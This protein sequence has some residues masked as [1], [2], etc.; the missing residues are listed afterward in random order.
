MQPR[1]CEGWRY[2]G[3]AWR[4]G[5]DGYAAAAVTR[6]CLRGLSTGR[7]GPAAGYI[8]AATCATGTGCA[9]VC[10]PCRSHWSKGAVGRDL[11]RGFACRTGAAVHHPA[12]SADLAAHALP[13]HLPVCCNRPLKHD[14]TYGMP[15]ACWSMHCIQC[16]P[17]R[18]R[19]PS[20][21]CSTVHGSTSSGTS[22][23]T[24]SRAQAPAWPD[25]RRREP[26]G[27]TPLLRAC[28]D[29]PLL[30]QRVRPHC[31]PRGGV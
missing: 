6:P 2:G 5:A 28:L 15:H 10:S 23:W 12:W 9:H 17:V 22:C 30:G 4:T 20:C 26:V 27:G 18:P 29:A 21:P 16:M 7:R 14:V 19:T 25:C 3:G 1:R 24:T 11:P 8:T 31:T 13:H